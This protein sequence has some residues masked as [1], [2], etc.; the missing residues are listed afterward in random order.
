[1]I[2]KGLRKFLN[3]FFLLYILSYIHYVLLYAVF[4]IRFSFC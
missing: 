2:I 1:M 4:A 3:S